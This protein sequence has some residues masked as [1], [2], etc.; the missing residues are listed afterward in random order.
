[1]E[2]VPYT[3]CYLNETMCYLNEGM[4]C[5]TPNQDSVSFDSTALCALLHDRHIANRIQAGAQDMHPL[6]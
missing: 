3:M 1:M 2:K 6:Y 5:V 4:P